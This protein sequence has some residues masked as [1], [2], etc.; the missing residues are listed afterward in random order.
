MRKN[1]FETLLEINSTKIDKLLEEHSFY[2]IQREELIEYLKA[3]YERYVEYTRDEKKEQ[4]EKMMRDA[5][6]YIIYRG[7][8]IRTQFNDDELLVKE[9][10]MSIKERYKEKGSLE[11]LSHFLDEISILRIS[12][13]T[14]SIKSF[15][16]SDNELFEFIGSIHNEKISTDNKKLNSLLRKMIEIYN[17]MNMETEKELR[18]SNAISFAVNNYTLPNENFIPLTK[19][20]EYE[21]IKRAQNGDDDAK[22]LI[23]SKNILL[24]VSFTLKYCNDYRYY[25]DVIQDSII[26][27]MEAVKRFD[28]SRENRLSTYAVEWIKKEV[29][30]GINLNINNV[31][32][33]MNLGHN[34]RKE[35]KRTDSLD[36]TLLLCSKMTI[37]SLLDRDLRISFQSIDLYNHLLNK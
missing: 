37:K 4:I 28:T 6:R 29:I 33:P 16:L 36:E 21:A 25:Q 14:Y 2:G 34:V 3:C 18:P 32:I 20:E 35:L 10:Y 7:D 17:K 19:E 1:G 24:I 31:R 9:V 13:S 11:V 5:K 8:E 23:I 27:L 12:L 30:N 26:G 15:I 22:K